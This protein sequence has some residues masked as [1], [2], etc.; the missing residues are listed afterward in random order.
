MSAPLGCQRQRFVWFHPPLPKKAEDR[1]RTLHEREMACN[2]HQRKARD[3]NGPPN[4]MG[5]RSKF[6]FAAAQCIIQ[7]T[8]A[9]MNSQIMG[10]SYYG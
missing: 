10:A 1:K 8:R 2:K 6:V 4:T 5:D 7:A 3:D 9:M